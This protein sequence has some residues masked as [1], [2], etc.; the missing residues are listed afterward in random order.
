LRQRAD[1]VPVAADVIGLVDIHE[2][3]AGHGADV[4][5][6]GKGLVRAGDDHA[7]DVRVGLE[8]VEGGADFIDQ[9]VVQRIKGLGP[10]ERD[11]PDLATGFDDDVFVT[12]FDVS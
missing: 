11:E 6:G 8:A 7:A 10:V 5:A 4:G 9:L 2:V 3:P 12:H 1:A